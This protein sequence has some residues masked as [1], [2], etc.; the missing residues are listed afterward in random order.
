M[1]SS[2]FL[3]TCLLHCGIEDKM[4]TNERL[5]KMALAITQLAYV[6]NKLVLNEGGLTNLVPIPPCKTMTTTKR[7]KTSYV[8]SKRDCHEGVQIRRGSRHLIL[9]KTKEEQDPQHNKALKKLEGKTVDLELTKPT[10]IDDIEMNK[11]CCNNNDFQFMN[12]KKASCALNKSECYKEI[13]KVK[14]VVHMSTKEISENQVQPKTKTLK[15][16]GDETVD[17]ELIQPMNLDDI[18]IK[19]IHMENS[20]TYCDQ[21]KQQTNTLNSPKDEAL[22]TELIKTIHVDNVELNKLHLQALS[23]CCEMNGFCFI[24]DTIAD[25][26][27]CCRYHTDEIQQAVG[28]LQQEEQNKAKA[29]SVSKH[30]KQQNNIIAENLLK[31]NGILETFNVD[32]H[33]KHKGNAEL[34]TILFKE[35]GIDA[36]IG[37]PQS[38]SKEEQHNCIIVLTQPIE[39]MKCLENKEDDHQNRLSINMELRQRQE[40]T[41]GSLLTAIKQNRNMNQ[42]PSLQ[43]AESTKHHIACQPTFRALERLALCMHEHGDPRNGI[44]RH[45]RL[46]QDSEASQRTLTEATRPAPRSL[47]RLTFDNG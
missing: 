41:Q 9:K 7:N 42:F 1:H 35:G 17:Y 12:N 33:N 4:N 30:N 46:H 5:G 15:T 23:T 3:K 26:A 45:G 13:Q 19:K 32:D 6:V 8:L 47:V 39:P 37:S 25:F 44:S 28:T 24:E 2:L 20:P 10:N 29:A 34:R 21:V 27:V 36:I 31:F 43:T 14:E 38:K 18:E 11:L 22:D 16:A 40:G